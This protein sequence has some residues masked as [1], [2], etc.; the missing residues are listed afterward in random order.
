MR[1]DFPVAGIALLVLLSIQREGAV[2]ASS[3]GR[4]Y[5]VDYPSGSTYVLISSGSFYGQK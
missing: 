3:D 4:V 1:I 5:S 2:L